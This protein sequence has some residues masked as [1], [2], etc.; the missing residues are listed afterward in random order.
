MRPFSPQQAK[1]LQVKRFNFAV[2]RV[3]FRMFQSDGASF[4]LFVNDQVVRFANPEAGYF[5][6]VAKKRAADFI[7]IY[8][9]HSNL[10]EII[11]AMKPRF[12]DDAELIGSHLHV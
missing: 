8:N 11:A 3:L 5:D 2:Y 7:G 4:A 12:S 1:A 6:L 9:G 10:E